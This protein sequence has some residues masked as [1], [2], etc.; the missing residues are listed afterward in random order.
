MLIARTN[1]VLADSADH[2]KYAVQISPIA[3][4]HGLSAGRDELTSRAP[5]ANPRDSQWHISMVMVWPPQASL[6][7]LAKDPS[8]GYKRAVPALFGLEMDM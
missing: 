2:P 3:P 6:G 1:K 8:Y 5:M 4:T 7:Y